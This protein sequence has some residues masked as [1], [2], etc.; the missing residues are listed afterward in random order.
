MIL[1]CRKI[2]LRDFEMHF[3]RLSANSDQN[4]SMEYQVGFDA[5]ISQRN[6]ILCVLLLFELVCCITH[7]VN[8]TVV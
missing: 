3:A 5:V 2:E 6:E 1:F 4:F 7:I 8:T